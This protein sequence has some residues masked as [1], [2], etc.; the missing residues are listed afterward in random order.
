MTSVTVG[1]SFKLNRRGFRRVK[2]VAAP[3]YT[4]YLTRIDALENARN[5]LEAEKKTLADENARLREREPETFIAILQALL[6][7]LPELGRGS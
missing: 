3:D 6:R 7:Q 5:I 1:L 2:P 4:P